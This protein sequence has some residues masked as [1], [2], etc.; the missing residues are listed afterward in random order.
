MWHQP[1]CYPLRQGTC[2][3][4]ARPEA[5]RDSTY[6]LWR[7]WHTHGAM[8]APPCGSFSSPNTHTLPST[9][10]PLPQVC[11]GIKSSCA[12]LP[13]GCCSQSWARLIVEKPFGRD[14]ASS[15]ALAG[16]LGS[17]FPE[18]QLYRIDHYLGKEL[19]QV[20][21]RGVCVWGGWVGGCGAVAPV[22]LPVV[23]CCCC[24]T[25]LASGGC[26]HITA[27]VPLR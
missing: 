25:H 7:A 4:L 1:V 2:R 6:S 5:I 24:G 15:E 8:Q 20:G 18:E 17:L 16:Q 11:A 9:P 21:G 22:V 3:R 13:A 12:E 26:G 23:L 27:A 14:L 19:A 10:L